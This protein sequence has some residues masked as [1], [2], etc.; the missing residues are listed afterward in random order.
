MI[1]HPLQQFLHGDA[2]A[3]M[4]SSWPC[5]VDANLAETD[6]F[7]KRTAGG[8]SDKIRETTFEACCLRDLERSASSARDGLA[9]MRAQEYSG[10]G[11]PIT[12]EKRSKLSINSAKK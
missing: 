12:G 6:R 5:F 1:A 11:D 7:H 8:I 4:P 2:I 10:S 3:P 9:G